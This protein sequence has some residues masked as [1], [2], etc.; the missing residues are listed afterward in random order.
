MARPRRL[1]TES[2]TDAPR[3]EGWLTVEQAVEWSSLS[4]SRLSEL[5]AAG[6]IVVSRVDRR[7]RYCKASLDAYLRSGVKAETWGRVVGG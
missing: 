1:I 4:R 2:V 3:P 6:K 5:E 7:P